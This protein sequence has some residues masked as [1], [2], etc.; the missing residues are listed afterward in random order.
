MGF[1]TLPGTVYLFGHIK[2]NFMGKEMMAI[3]VKRLYEKT[4]EPFIGFYALMRPILLIR[5]PELIRHILIKDF[6]HFQ[7]RGVYV[8]EKDDPLSGHLVALA[9]EKWKGLRAKLT[10]TFTSG[11]LKGM[12]STLV[13][14]GS[15]LQNYLD[16]L[17]EKS[18][19][20]DVQE[21]AASHATNVIASVSFGID[22]DA[23]TDPNTDFRKYGRKM[24]S[25]NIQNSLR[26][27]LLTCAPKLMK[28][29]H[30]KCVSADV[31]NFVLSIVKQ[32]LEYR[33]MNNVTRNDFFQLL[34]QLRNTGSVESD[35]HDSTIKSN[36]NQKTLTV[37]EMAAQS[38]IFF[39]AGFETSSS[40]LAFCLFELARNPEIQ[41][42]AFDEISRV[43][44]DHGG[45]ITYDAVSEMKFLEQCID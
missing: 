36:E 17:A 31:E 18:E 21:I 10:P 30:I 41:N 7:D 38:Y 24:F 29:L 43:L 27:I 45:E 40:T 16:K 19:L 6:S 12:F 44:E 25:P 1:K 14:C 23:I 15:N 4:S 28:F 8:N 37:N 13:A 26:L 39:A 11:K 20:L 33:E 42:R 3:I 34:I 22:V 9:G 2:S 32:N 5:D 35:G